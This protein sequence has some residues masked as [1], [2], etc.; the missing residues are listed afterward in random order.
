VKDN[1]VETREETRVL[2][3]LERLCIE[4]NLLE[5]QG[6]PLAASPLDSNEADLQLLAEWRTQLP[7]LS[8][9]GKIYSSDC[10]VD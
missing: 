8:N 1:S 9:T 4:K 3:S 10:D 7:P 5:K 6:S 2:E